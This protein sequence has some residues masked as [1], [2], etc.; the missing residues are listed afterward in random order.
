LLRDHPDVDIVALVE[1][2]R[3]AARAA[4]QRDA[5]DAP[6][7]DDLAAAVASTAPEVVVNLTPPAIHRQIV[8]AAFALGCHVLSEKPLAMTL[9]DAQALVTAARRAGRW[10]SVMQNRRFDHGV[11]TMRDGIAEGRIGRPSML[12][13]DLL[14]APHFGGFRDRMASPLLLDMAIHPFDQARLLTGLEPVAVTCH[15]FNPVGSWYAGAA[16]AV[17]LFEL[18]DGSVFSFRGS[19]AAPGF[20]THWNGMWRVSGSTGTVLWDGEGDPIGEVAVQPTAPALFHPTRRQVWERTWPGRTGHAGCL[21]EMLA[22]L[23]LDRPAE[24]DA[25]DNVRSL[26]MVLGALES[27]R[28][29]GVRVTLDELHPALRV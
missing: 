29:G 9:D 11:R 24:T 1:L 5:I 19:W 2:D 12:A 7:F 18:E 27:A 20:A 3:A 8:E 21:D 23:R 26:T 14:L 13:C 15:E 25:A 6:I 28:R 4:L 22:A 10:L 16:A 17:C